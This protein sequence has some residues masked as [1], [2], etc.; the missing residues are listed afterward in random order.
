V[1]TLQKSFDAVPGAIWLLLAAAVASILGLTALVIA[2]LYLRRLER[3][4]AD[5]WRGLLPSSG[6]A[7]WGWGSA[8][9]SVLAVPLSTL[10]VSEQSRALIR[11]A[12]DE[13]SKL[14]ARQRGDFFAQGL[15]GALNAI[16]LGFSMLWGPS[17]LLGTI[18]CALLLS[19]ASTRSELARASQQAYWQRSAAQPTRRLP[20]WGF[21]LVAVLM[22][23]CGV[24]PMVLLATDY[25]AKLMIGLGQASAMPSADKGPHVVATFE[26]ARGS[27]ETGY[28]VVLGA[29]ALVTAGGF[30]ILRGARGSRGHALPAPP[31]VAPPLFA[32]LACLVLAGLLFAA[33]DPYRAENL[34]P[35]PIDD[36]RSPNVL[37]QSM[38]VQPVPGLS[39]PD[40]VELAPILEIGA[41]QAWLDGRQVDAAALETDLGIL[42]SNWERLHPDSEFS[43]YLAVVCA[44]ETSAE[45]LEE[46][47]LAA[48]RARYVRPQFV[49]GGYSEINRPVMG[50]LKRA[51]FSAADFVSVMPAEFSQVDWA[52]TIEAANHRSCDD[53]AR[54]VVAVRRK[55]GDP[56]FHLRPGE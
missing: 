40:A 45:R 1:A 44:R 31:V 32:A 28:R 55:G 21:T 5:A 46:M 30:A 13:S 29:I 22:M 23:L 6:A 35:L 39:G 53:V 38:R 20:W 8:I 51:R 26:A 24:V 52:V 18:S 56:W 42:R 49:F 12:L 4:R 9:T 34:D 47:M 2:G 15:S 7:R 41:A 10:M 19:A 17:L 37:P 50:K 16:P 11:A 27:F 14:D 36:A 43:G 3:A 33:T 25:A 54:A 48:H